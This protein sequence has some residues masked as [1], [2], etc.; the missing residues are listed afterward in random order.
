MNNSE[1]NL[2]PAE[3]KLT[4]YLDGALSPA[5]A[6]AFEREN[7]SAAAERTMHEKLRGALAAKVPALK[8][9]EFFN[10]QILREIAPA[11]PAR[12]R[13]D[14][15]PLWRLALAAAVCVLAAAGIYFGMVSE[16]KPR[17]EYFAQV[18][19]VTAGDDKISAQLLNADGLA[20]VWVDGLASLPA[21]YVLE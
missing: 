18:L 2:S 9:G 6:Q 5:E 17:T 8:N 10:H 11:Q 19:S 20:I 1:P 16:P 13:N 12:K 3:E 14:F 15:F 21:D 7:P 4:A